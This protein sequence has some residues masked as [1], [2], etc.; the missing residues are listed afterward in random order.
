MAQLGADVEQLAALSRKFNE[1]AGQIESMAQQITSQV[2][3]AWWQGRDADRFRSEWRSHQSQLKNAAQR[4]EQE[5][6][7][8]KQQEQQQ[9]QTSGA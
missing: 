1:V 2:E 4:L 5:A 7:R 3:S 9:R 8:V 6:Q